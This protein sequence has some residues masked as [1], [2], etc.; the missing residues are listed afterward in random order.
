MFSQEQVN[1]RR[2]RAVP[3]SGGMLANTFAKRPRYF[4]ELLDKIVLVKN[5]HSGDAAFIG[6]NEQQRSGRD[7]SVLSGDKPSGVIVPDNV[8]H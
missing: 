1:D 2:D 3:R 5:V 4:D 8:G 7:R 6:E